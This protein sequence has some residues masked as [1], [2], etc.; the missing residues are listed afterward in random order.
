MS[1]ITDMVIFTGMDEHDAMDRL[2]AWCGQNDPRKQQFRPLD[3]DAA[4]GSK[5]FCGEV[6]AMAGNYFPHQ[7]LIE[8]FA[9]FN[10]R[11]PEHVVLIVDAETDDRSAV[12]RPGVM[13]PV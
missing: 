6:W 10:W 3:P 12:V 8:T 11:Y 13:E 2:N 1:L 7:Q 5:F 4:G 9:D